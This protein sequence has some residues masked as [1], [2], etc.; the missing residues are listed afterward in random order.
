MYLSRAHSGA[1]ALA[2][3]QEQLDSLVAHN[4]SRRRPRRSTHLHAALAVRELPI[5]LRCV[6]GQQASPAC[7]S[8][9]C[10][11]CCGGC[12]RHGYAE[13]ESSSSVEQALWCG[14]GQQ[15]SLACDDGRCGRCCRGCSRH[16]Y[17]QA[18]PSS[19]AGQARWCGC[20]QQASPACD[21]GAC[22][23][24]CRG[25]SRHAAVNSTCSSS[26]VEE[27]E[28]SY[29][30]TQE[31]AGGFPIWCACGKQASPACDNQECGRCCGGCRRHAFAA[32][33]GDGGGADG[34]A[35][36]MFSE[37]RR[38]DCGTIAAPGCQ[39]GECGAC[40]GGCHIHA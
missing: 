4:C 19:G 34:W 3:L 26:Y 32:R 7:D 20:G 16:G 25:C 35:F 17:A 30:H 6:C 31:G 11:A 15:A 29:H 39:N 9:L 10:A 21:F 18:E 27:S 33:E 13:A 23:S 28:A 8:K 14:C 38:C 12:S 5:E 36:A 1:A 40:C 37:P 24:C 2:S 22:G